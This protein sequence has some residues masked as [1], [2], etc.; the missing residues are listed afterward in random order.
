MD[1][2]FK[3]ATVVVSGGT[4]GMGRAAADCFA[5]DG[6]KVA[7]LARSKAALDAT[8]EELSALGSPDAVGIQT[9]LFDAGSVDAAL[10]QVGERWGQLN[11]LVNAAG[12]MALNLKTF[13]TYTDEEWHSVLSGLTLSAVRTIRAALPLLRAAK[14]ARI[15]NVSAM[16]TKRQSPP[17]IAYTAAKSALTSLSKNLSQTLAPEGILVNTVSPGTFASE[18]FKQALAPIPDVDENDLYDVM[19]YI[20]RGFGHHVFLDRAADPAEIGPVI[21]FAASARNTYMTGANINV[22]GGSD[23]V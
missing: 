10:A 18:S 23:F 21:A 14:W 22:D 1:L 4:A 8:V 11:A 7:V 19:R 9:D 13:E 2:G 16:S 15:V 3:D 17:L 5:A 12:P 6:A 20:G